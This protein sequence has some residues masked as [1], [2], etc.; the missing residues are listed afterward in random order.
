ME[1][2]PALIS[3]PDCQRHFPS[4]PEL[5]RH[6]ELLHRS[7]SGRNGDEADEIPRPYRCVQCGRGYRHAGSLVNHRRTHEI[8]LFPCTTCN[9]DFSN[10]MALKSHL[11]THVPEG[12]KRRRPP[13]HKEATSYTQ[14]QMTTTDICRGMPGPGENWNN[15]ANHGQ[16]THVWEAEPEPRE[17]SGTWE[18]P[19]G[20]KD[21][22]ENRTNSKESTEGWGNTSGPTE[23]PALP[24]PTSSLLSNLEQYLAESMVDFTGNERPPQS[25]PAEDERRYKCGQCGKTYKHAGSLTNHRQSHAL[26]VYPC[27]VCFKEFS[28]LMALKNHSRLHAQYRPYQCPQCPRAFRLPSELLGHQQVHEGEGKE[29]PWEEKGEPSA[30]GHDRSQLHGTKELNASGEFSTSGEFDAGDLNEGGV[31]EYRP[32]R[33]ADCGRTYRHAGS[34]INHRKSHETGVYPCP[35]CPKQLFNA[36][37]LKNHLRA[38][39]KARRSGGE[40]EQQQQPPPPTPLP[41]LMALPPEV[42]PEEEENP[43]TPTTTTDHRPYKCNECGRAYRHRGS[44]VNH[45]HSHQTGEYQCS[46]CPRQYP[47][48]MALRNHVRVH[49]KAA[50]RNGSQGREEPLSHDGECITPGL[51]REDSTLSHEEEC[52]EEQQTTQEEEDPSE[53]GTIDSHPEVDMAVAQICGL[54]GMLFDDIES[55][56]QHGQTHQE[57]ENN[58]GESSE[59]PPRAYSCRDCGKTYRHSGSLINHRQTHQTGDFGCGTCAKHFH[60]VAAMKS[61]LRRHSRRRSKR[62]QLRTS[63]SSGGSDSKV[64]VTNRNESSPEGYQ[65]KNLIVKEE[66]KEKTD[67]HKDLKVNGINM[68]NDKLENN[69]NCFQNNIKKDNCKLERNDCSPSNEEDKINEKRLAGKESSFLG[70]LITGNKGGSG[71][72]PALVE[73]VHKQESVY[74]AISHG[75]ETLNGWRTSGHHTCHDCGRSFHHTAG[76][77]NHRPCHPPGI[78]QCSLCPKEFDSLPALRSHFQNHGPGEATSGQPFLCCLCGMI[79]PGRA[80]YRQ[81]RSQVHDSPGENQGSS[82][83]EEEEALASN[84]TPLQLSEAELLNQLQREVEGLDG[85]GYG[86]I[87]ACCGQT[88]DD[89][90]SLERHH[91]SLGS[92]SVDGIDTIPTDMEEKEGISETTLGDNFESTVTSISQDDTSTI[93]EACLDTMSKDGMEVVGNVDTTSELGIEGSSV[94]AVPESLSPAQPRPFQCN[95]CGKTYRHGGSLVNHRKTHQ[96]GDFACPICARRYPNLA[97]YRNHLRNH[98]RCKGAEPQ[99]GVIPVVE[100][101]EPEKAAEIGPLQISSEELQKELKENAVEERAIKKEPEEPSVKQEDVPPKDDG[102]EEG[103]SEEASMD[104]PFGCELCGRTYKHAGSLINHR[105]SHQTGHFGCQACSKGFSNLMALKNHR[106]I[107]AEPRRFHCGE[108]GKA[109]RLRKQLA[110][111]Q[112]VH[113]E[114][115][116]GNSGGSRKLLSTSPSLTRD[117]RPFH[118]GQCGR[119]YRHAGSLLNHRRSHEIGQYSCPTCPKTYSN[120]MALKN[121]QRLHSE[122]RRRRAGRVRRGG[123]PRVAVRCALCGH[124]L[125]RRGSLERH[126]R[127]HEETSKKELDV[128][129]VLSQTTV[130]DESQ[131]DIHEPEE[132]SCEYELGAQVDNQTKGTQELGQDPSGLSGSPEGSGESLSWTQGKTDGW[133]INETPVSI[134][135]SQKHTR[136]GDYGLGNTC[137]QEDSQLKAPEPSTL[138]GWDSGQTQDQDNSSQSQLELRPFCCGQCGKTYR[139]AGS[140]LNHRNTHKTGHY[141]CQLC[142]KEFSNPMA[143]KNHGRI[144]TATR[145]FMCP[146]CGKAFR[147]SR[148]LTSHQRGH[149]MDQGQAPPQVEEADGQKVETKR[150]MED[151]CVSGQGET[152]RASEEISESETAMKEAKEVGLKQATE[153]ERPFCCTQ[154]GRS[155]R[156]AGSLLN[157]QKA[158]AT[159][160]YPCSLCPKLLPNLLA[161]KNHGRTHT[162]PKRHRCGICGKAFRTAARL[163]GHGRVHA[164]REGPFSCPHCPRRFRRQISFLQ[165]QQ[166]HKEEWTMTSTGDTQSPTARDVDLSSPLHPPP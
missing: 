130:K 144:H 96:T 87:C 127:E 46:L 47:N 124:S 43:A 3:C 38:H 5:A 84:S 95:Q 82:E 129:K 49:F 92:I 19:P 160:L 159:G 73:G 63:G 163:E 14:G 107:H 98:P 158:H 133:H 35:V 93:S 7:P 126:L 33:C 54:C 164:P 13:R 16:S 9:K 120:R 70:N 60:T 1:D 83:D 135:G 15:Q 18:K 99:L 4:L 77:L 128:I 65:E 100:S 154:C 26:G 134:S 141:H 131:V 64:V 30:N 97:A 91:Q 105:Q 53:E 40:E 50:R 137:S 151:K 59:S 72:T 34:L 68:A 20:H 31:E 45:R 12:R 142:S 22:W 58:R 66:E 67:F 44:L 143:A 106:R 115:R 29:L 6:R 102:I 8:G 117:E 79:F 118:C 28:N 94:E 140:L 69:E 76:L 114:R 90:G 108:C 136:P 25:P 23:A 119:T 145:R 42:D 71:D 165:H 157:H 139:H 48:L 110:N 101:K 88:Y 78:Y 148:E 62:H 81:H 2:T 75:P 17:A 32:F 121:H 36:A 147:A 103:N 37:A 146:H 122:S 27:A 138:E 55:L 161:L 112:R 109:F 52:P 11:R 41:S 113:G 39:L 149:A 104:R 166:Q 57:G 51:E 125:P 61:H 21:G 162:D 123:G 155:Y 89:L 10:P 111:H 152:Q 156:H 150:D 24:A 132:R 80:D 116:N 56:K 153:E 86:H 74:D 85:A